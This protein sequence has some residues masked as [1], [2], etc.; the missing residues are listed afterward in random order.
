MK[1]LLAR[2]AASK[3]LHI[4]EIIILANL[5]IFFFCHNL[6]SV[7]F[8]PDETYWITSTSSRYDKFIKG[9]FSDSV[10]DTSFAS[11]EVRPVPG[12]LVSA[13]QRL[14][15]ITPDKLPSKNW[16]WN[17]DSQTNI[18][19]GALPKSRAVYYSRLP[20]AIITVFSLLITLIFISCFHS[21]LAAYCFFVF[22]FN[23]FFLVYLRRAMSESPLLIFTILSI[24]SMYLL[25]QEIEN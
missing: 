8:F 5:Y 6:L 22:S 14:A 10:W 4:M 21:R 20:M 7:S 1:R 9:D 12:Y 15:G 17:V 3:Q 18:A 11:F 25:L 24:V 2:L 19:N 13:S 16:D 23:S